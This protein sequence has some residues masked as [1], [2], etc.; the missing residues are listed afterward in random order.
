MQSIECAL[1]A[2][3]LLGRGGGVLEPEA[4]QR[5]QALLADRIVPLLLL[6]LQVWKGGARTGRRPAFLAAAHALPNV[7]C[8]GRMR[9]PGPAPAGAADWRVACVASGRDTALTRTAA[10]A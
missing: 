2:R 6:C 1:L 3:S 10:A 4:E 9:W 8:G 5:L 7:A